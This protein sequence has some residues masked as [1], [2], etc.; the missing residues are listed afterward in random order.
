M[1]VDVCN[2][3]KSPTVYQCFISREIVKLSI[4]RVDNMIRGA[5]KLKNIFIYVLFHG[6]IDRLY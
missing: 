2:N 3:S 5:N 1:Y 4:I 6:L